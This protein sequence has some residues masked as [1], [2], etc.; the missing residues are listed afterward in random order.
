M[1]KSSKKSVACQRGVF[2]F[3]F[4]CCCQMRLDIDRAI[5]DKEI[6]QW[7]RTRASRAFIE[8]VILIQNSNVGTKKNKKTALIVITYECNV[9]Y[10]RYM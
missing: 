6:V 3:S 5:K 2:A 9:Y 7:K 4:C 8:N 1:L 10:T